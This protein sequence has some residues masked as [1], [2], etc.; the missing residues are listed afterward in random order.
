VSEPLLIDIASDGLAA[1]IDTLGAEL[2]AL[3]D[4][5][6]RDLLWNGDP[7]VWSGRAPILF[8]IIGMLNG[9]RYRLDGKTF[10]LAKHGFARRKPFEV[11]STERHRATLR[12]GA[13]DQTLASYPF[14]FELDVTY[15]LQAATL[16]M[17]AEIRNLGDADMPASFGFHPAFRRPLPFGQPRADHEIRFAQP[18]PEPIRRIDADSLLQPDG[19]PTPVIGDTLL[20]RDALFDADAVIF[21][22]LRSRTLRYGA[23]AGPALEIDFPDT[24][25]LGVWAKPGADFVA[26]EP[27]HGVN[28][29]EGFD[30]DIWQKPGIFAVGPG[31]A[32]Q[33]AMSVTLRS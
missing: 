15:A 21:D 8:P 25:Y 3:R 1:Q 22:R 18:E 28:D 5:D 31:Q 29:A 33:C 32:R 19:Q 9:G 16:T 14:Q 4:R 10:D 20:L 26:I 24:P 17:T 30:S 11:I 7:Q 6:G 2:H 27:W 23:K 13:D 12:L